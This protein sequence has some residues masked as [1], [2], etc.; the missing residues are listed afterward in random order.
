MVEDFVALRPTT[1]PSLSA[2][3]DTGTLW[4]SVSCSECLPFAYLSFLPGILR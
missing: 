3:R 1:N 4:V 2:T